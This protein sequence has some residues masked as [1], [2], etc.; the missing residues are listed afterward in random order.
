MKKT[1][2]LV[3]TFLLHLV[4]FSETLAALPAVFEGRKLYVSYCLICHGV[5]GKGDGPLAKSM[6]IT[7]TDFNTE[8]R[9]K[10]DNVL[11]K[12]ITGG[13][14]H[15]AISSAMP[16]WA[17]VLRKSEVSALIAYLRFLSIQQHP[18]MGDPEVGRRLYNKHC[19]M[20]HGRQGDGNG[21]MKDLINIK[22]M[23]HT[24][25]YKTNKLTNEEIVMDILEGKGKYMPAWKSVLTQRDA[26]GLVGYI[27][28]LSQIWERL[29]KGGLVIIMQPMDTFEG[30][31]DV[32]T[33]DSESAC[34]EKSGLS[35]AG[36]KQ[37]EILSEFFKSRNV[38][39]EEVM[40]SSSCQAKETDDLIKKLEHEIASWKGKDNLLIVTSE[41]IIR[42]ITFKRLNR[43]EES[44]V[45]MPM[46]DS[47]FEVIGKFKYHY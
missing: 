3:L 35:E 12:S 45:L 2:R 7:P 30:S 33:K 11:R 6:Q 18:L 38:L 47:G 8:I 40:A 32:A 16:N 20:C 43:R 14:L 39:I 1:V 25:A 22:P 37:A 10:N 13:R 42:A 44:L 34:V 4:V 41:Q 31:G 15:D 5:E 21:F 19:Q 36:N 23:D 29:K 17:N 46:E 24:N 28:L 9:N 26:E 27:R